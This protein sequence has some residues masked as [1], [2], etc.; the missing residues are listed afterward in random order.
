MSDQQY[1]ISFWNEEETKSKTKRKLMDKLAEYNGTTCTDRVEFAAFIVEYVLSWP[2][3]KG[4][5]VEYQPN[6][7]TGM[8]E[9]NNTALIIIDGGFAGFTFHPIKG[10]WSPIR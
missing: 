5:L 3:G 4:I 10:Q 1:L 8:P 7:L 2:R 9:H 6:G